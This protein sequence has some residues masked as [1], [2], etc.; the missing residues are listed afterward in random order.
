MNLH[1]I[2]RGAITTVN[3]DIAAQWR[4]S[5]GSTQ[6]ANFKQVPAYA[7]AVPV[8]IQS[9]PLKYSDQLHVQALN[10]AGIF[11][12]VHMFGLNQGITRPNQKGGDYLQFPQAPGMAAQWW[13]TISVRE[14][15]P[16]WCRVLVCLQTS[17]PP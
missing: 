9:Q 15:W 5:A 10:L 17:G 4:V 8:R 11:R 1:G 6:G 13:L 3:P 12:S 7:T 2:V 16:D 14:Q